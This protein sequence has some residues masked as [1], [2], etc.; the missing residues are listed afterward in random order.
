[1]ATVYV[2]D[3]IAAI[4]ARNSEKSLVEYTNDKLIEGIKKDFDIEM[5]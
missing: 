3:K 4:I 2:K 1:M 5:N